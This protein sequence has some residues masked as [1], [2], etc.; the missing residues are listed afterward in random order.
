MLKKRIQEILEPA[1]PEGC[2]TAIETIDLNPVLCSH[3]GGVAV[4]ARITLKN[5]L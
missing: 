2:L 4:D 5:S 1:R 3:Q